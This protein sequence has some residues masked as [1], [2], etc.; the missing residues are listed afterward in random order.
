MKEMPEWLMILIVLIAF[1]IIFYFVVA[2]GIP[3]TVA[4][5]LKAIIKVVWGVI[6]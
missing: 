3:T 1:F 2:L 5:K 4:S 6:P